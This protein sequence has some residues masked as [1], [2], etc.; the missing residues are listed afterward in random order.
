VVTI[1]IPLTERETV[2][3]IA[4]S[5]PRRRL[6]TTLA[7]A[8][9]VGAAAVGL[10]FSAV[11]GAHAAEGGS[12]GSDMVH[13]TIVVVSN[14]VP[15]DQT[16][17]VALTANGSTTCDVAKGATPSFGLDVPRDSVV[18]L[19]GMSGCTTAVG[20]RYAVRVRDGG[21]FGVTL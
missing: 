13:V 6:R 12:S 11:G 1:P 16:P 14:S 2:M 5:A 10:G 18:E 17:T 15:A 3:S 7:A 9:L 4:T 19:I 21:T 8:G 20:D